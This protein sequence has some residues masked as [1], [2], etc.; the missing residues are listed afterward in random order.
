MYKKTKVSDSGK[1]CVTVPFVIALLYFIGAAPLEYGYYTFIRWL[2]FFTLPTFSFLNALMLSDPEEKFLN[3]TNIAPLVIALIFNPLEPLH[4]S[5]QV[6]SVI[7]VLAGAV[8]LL[9]GINFIY[10]RI[11]LKKG[12]FF[13]EQ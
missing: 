11:Y 2:S 13:I 12:Y 10:V 1:F 3:F 5:K 4:F 7:D 9:I 6:W 8:M